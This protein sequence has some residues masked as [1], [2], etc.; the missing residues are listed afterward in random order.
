LFCFIC[1]TIEMGRKIRPERT[2]KFVFEPPTQYA[3]EAYVK[4]K[5]K[6]LASMFRDEE[7]RGVTY[8]VNHDFAPSSVLPPPKVEIV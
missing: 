3:E 6:Q 4:H 1:K 7:H 8:D 5:G 2:D